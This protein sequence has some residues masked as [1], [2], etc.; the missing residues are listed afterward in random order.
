MFAAIFCTNCFISSLSDIHVCLD[1]DYD[2]E[3][4]DFVLF[5]HR[6]AINGRGE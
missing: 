5:S 4:L 2:Y 3:D 1:Y 6:S